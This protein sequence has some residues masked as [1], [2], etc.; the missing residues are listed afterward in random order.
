LAVCNRYSPI[1]HGPL[2]DVVEN[3]P[4][5]G[6]GDTGRRTKRHDVAARADLERSAR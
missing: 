3:L 1:A 2:S 4:E 5:S 6:Y